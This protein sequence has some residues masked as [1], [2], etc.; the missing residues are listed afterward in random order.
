MSSKESLQRAL[1]RIRD[2][3]RAMTQHAAQI[4]LS[5]GTGFGIGYLHGRKGEMPKLLGSDTDPSKGVPYDVLGAGLMYAAAFSSPKYASYALAVGNVLGGYF[6]AGIGAKM[7]QQARKDAGEMSTPPKS[8]D[9]TITKGAA[10]SHE[11]RDQYTQQRAIGAGVP[12]FA[13]RNAHHAHV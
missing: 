10:E 4:A 5:L 6:T 11:Y 12:H 8:N 3:G 1:A 13:P 2:N 7:G 9:R